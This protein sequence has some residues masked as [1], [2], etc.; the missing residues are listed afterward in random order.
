MHS[1]RDVSPIDVFRA[2]RERFGHMRER[3]LAA[4]DRVG[5]RAALVPATPVDGVATLRIYDV[6]DSWGGDWGISANEV[7]QALDQIGDVEEIRVRLNSP[8][9]EVFEGIAIMNLLRSHPARVTAVVDGLA[10]SAASF[11]ATSA[12][13]TTMGPN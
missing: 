9:G 11:L 6:I 3:G 8:G 7:A 5:P 10:A 1:P 2:A 4:P 13:D 12:D